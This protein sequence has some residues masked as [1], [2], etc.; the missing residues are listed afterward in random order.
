MQFIYCRGCHTL[1]VSTPE[2]VS[3]KI[4]K[5]R[6]SQRSH[7]IYGEGILL[8]LSNRDFRLHSN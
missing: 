5:E 2:I 4:Y 7:L 1:S 3:K 8:G 6:S